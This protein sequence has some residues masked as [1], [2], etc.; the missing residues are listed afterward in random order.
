MVKSLKI[1]LLLCLLCSLTAVMAQQFPLWERL[2]HY[3]G[4]KTDDT[5]V[6]AMKMGN[7]MQMSLK[8]KPQQGDQQR[9]QRIV[10][11]ARSVV[12]H[13][14]DV[15]TAFRDGYRP[16]HPT[17]RRGPLHELPL[18][19]SGA[20]PRELRSS[21][22][23]P[24]QTHA[25]GHAGRGRHVHCP[26][27]FDAGTSECSRSAKHR[28][29]APS[30]GLLRWTA[31]LA[32]RRP[33]WAPCAVWPA[34]EYPHRRGMPRGARTLDSSGLRMDD[35]CLPQRKVSERRVGRDGHAYGCQRRRRRN[36]AVGVQS[37]AA[38]V[39]FGTWFA[40]PA[41]REPV[42]RLYGLPISLGVEDHSCK[43]H[44]G[45]RILRDSRRRWDHSSEVG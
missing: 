13:Y 41:R 28:Y 42:R 32:S 12:A 40:H 1:I 15:N 20:A 14:S 8:D 27:R 17:G 31:K 43:M 25:G 45:P 3:S 38:V 9:A 35:S 10:A 7:H 34:R 23:D 26:A 18:Q 22:I 30:C 5:P 21:G 11:A 4:G 44:L 19:P 29:L 24:V 33:I 6:P 16:F 39:G 36:E 2:L 37:C